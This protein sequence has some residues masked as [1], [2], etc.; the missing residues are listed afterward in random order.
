MF[1]HVAPFGQLDDWVLCRVREKISSPRSTWEELNEPSYEPLSDFQQMNYE[2]RDPE[3]TVKNHVLSEY[4][5]LPYI[6]RSKK[7]IDLLSMGNP[8]SSLS[9]QR[10]DHAFVNKDTSNIES[11]FSEF[12]ANE[13]LM[14]RKLCEQSQI[15]LYNS[16]PIKKL[17]EEDCQRNVQDIDISESYN[18]SFSSFFDHWNAIIQPQE[19]NNLA[20]AG[21]V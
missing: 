18:S 21:Y 8:S 2:S 9:N 5:M 20:F 6:L 15:D 13:S 11:Q 4:P 7:N 10:N 17:R 1:P 14:K 19:L 12:T 3:E 16:P